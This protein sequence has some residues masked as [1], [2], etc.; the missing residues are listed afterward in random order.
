MVPN[1]LG[2]YGSWALGYEGGQA[3]P[4]SFLQPAWNRVEEWKEAARRQ[5]E[6]RIGRPAGAAGRKPAAEREPPAGRE[7][8]AVVHEPAAGREPPVRV[9]KATA[10][11]DLEIE[12]L[13]WQLPYGPPTEAVFLKP[14][15]SKGKLPGVLG[16]HDHGGNKYFGKRKITRTSDRVH[17]LMVAHQN[18]YYGGVAWANELARRGYGV[19][20]H[21]GFPF[22]SRKVLASDLP[23]YV[24]RRLMA[25]AEALEELTPAD[26]AGD[27]AVTDYDVPADEPAQRIRAYNGFAA[28]HEEI[29]AKSLFSAGLT[30]PGL[31]VDEDRRALDYLC[32]RPDIDPGRIGCCGL[33]GGGLRTNYLAG[34]DDR[35]RC[36]VTA[37]FMTTW[38]DFLFHTCFTH[39]WMIYIPLLPGLMEYP[40]ILGMRAPLP[41]LVLAT[42]EDPLFTIEEVRRAA[43]ILEKLYAKAGGPQKMRFSLYPG[44]HQFN[45]AMQKEAFEWLDRWL[46]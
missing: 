25:P 38:R 23:G 12:E 21:D 41:S 7:P 33:S 36:A 10:W 22:E 11:Q 13:T 2:V 39:T 46:K 8:P 16:F 35:I 3:R 31:F 17:P 19:L 34:L 43:G 9:C 1:M 29:I 37:G 27:A 42:E 26:K 44:P 32:S 15:G 14:R 20:V 4:L 45:R 30:W 24:V 18:Q 5:V 40:E 28:R 6:E